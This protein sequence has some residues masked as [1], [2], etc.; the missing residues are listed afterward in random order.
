MQTPTHLLVAAT[1]LAQPDATR[2]N[3]ALIAGALLPDLSIYVLFAW[4]K[5]AGIA[6]RQVWDVIYWQEPW[7]TLSAISNSVPLWGLIL[8]IGMLVARSRRAVGTVIVVMAI[9]ALLHLALDFPFHHDDAH[10]HFWPLTDWRFASPLSYWDPAHHGRSVALAEVALAVGCVVVL[11]RRIVS[12]PVRAILVGALM[13]YV[14]VPL[15]FRLA[16]A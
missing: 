10:K 3:G 9:A 15:Y 1:V 2:R 7:Q 12:W 11:W 8:A 14:A 16:L 13:A 4:S 5:Y 6:E